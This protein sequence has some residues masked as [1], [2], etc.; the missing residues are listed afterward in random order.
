M[1]KER[2]RRVTARVAS[3]IDVEIELDKSWQRLR[4]VDLSLGG[5]CLRSNLA[6]VPPHPVALRLHL[7][8]GRVLATRGEV[9][10]IKPA[11]EQIGIQFEGMAPE[12]LLVWARF[13]KDAGK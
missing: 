11:L 9:C 7:P 3:A 4:S 2:H 12:D 5:L 13:L 8:G 10:W 6:H 1:T